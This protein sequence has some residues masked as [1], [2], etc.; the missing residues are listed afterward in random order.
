MAYILR[1]EIIHDIFIEHLKTAPT[2][3]HT[4]LSGM[5]GFPDERGSVIQFSDKSF[6]VDRKTKSGDI[7]AF[8]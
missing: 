8:L 2:Y 6:R 3:A 7:E 4:R 5:D 1:D